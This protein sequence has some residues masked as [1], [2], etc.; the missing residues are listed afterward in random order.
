[1]VSEYRRGWE[2]A[3]DVVMELGDLNAAER[4]RDRIREERIRM[5]YRG[6]FISDGI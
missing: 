4:I 2:D 6:P 5:M 3:L 1:M